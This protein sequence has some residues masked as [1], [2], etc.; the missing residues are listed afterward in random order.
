MMKNLS[1]RTDRSMF[2]RNSPI[3]ESNG[4]SPSLVAPALIGRCPK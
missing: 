1:V 4:A 3:E 2:E